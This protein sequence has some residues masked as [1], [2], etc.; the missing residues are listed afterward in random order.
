MRDNFKFSLSKKF[1]KFE[2]DFLKKKLHLE[3]FW[4]QSWNCHY[5]SQK[6]FPFFSYDSLTIYDGGSSVSPI[7]GKYCGAS[8]P[9]SQ[10][11]SSNEIFIHFES[12]GSITETGF[13]L[14]YNPIGKWLPKATFFICKV[15]GSKLQSFL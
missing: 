6:S 8:I 10:I 11:S 14:E 9:Q 4:S 13:K 1:M 15:K 7:L 12:D 5:P 3:G 2:V